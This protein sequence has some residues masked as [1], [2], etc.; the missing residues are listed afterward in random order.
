MLPPSTNFEQC[1]SV[2]G[3]FPF[4]DALKT[5]PSPALVLSRMS[6]NR[7]NGRTLLAMMTTAEHTPW[8]SDHA[9]RDLRPKGLRDAR[10]LRWKLVCSRALHRRIGHRREGHTHCCRAALASILD[11]G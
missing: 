7:G 2:I 9:I 8:Q 11:D 5:K 1:D 4:V 6:F 3:L 10:V